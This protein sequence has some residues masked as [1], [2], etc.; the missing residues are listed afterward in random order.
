MIQKENNIRGSDKII[1]SLIHPPLSFLF[2]GIDESNICLQPSLGIAYLSATLRK[3]GHEVVVFDFNTEI[4]SS[5]GTEYKH[6]WN[7]LFVEFW[8][9]EKKFYNTT[10][11]II[12][13]KINNALN[14][15]LYTKPT[16]IGFSLWSTSKLVSCYMAKKIKEK[17]NKSIIIFGGPECT[18]NNA[19]YFIEKVGADAVVIGEGEETL[20]E[21]IRNFKKTGKLNPCKGGFF[22]IE[23]KIIYGGKRELIR[24][25]NTLPFPDFSDFVKNYSA[26]P[27][28]EVILPVSW[29][30]GCVNRC[31]FCYESLF[32]EYPRVRSPEVICEELEY[33][34]KKYNNNIFVKNDSTISI[35]GEHISRVCD[36]LIERQICL[37]WGG[38]ARIENYLTYNLLKK[39]H[40]AGCVYLEYGIESGSQKIVNAMGKNFSLKKAE[41][42]LAATKK[43]GLLCGVHVMYGYPGE[44]LFDFMKTVHFLLKNR[45]SI[46]WV[47]PSRFYLQPSP[48]FINPRKY[49]VSIDENKKWH[50]GKFSNAAPVVLVE[51]Y[52]LLMFNILFYRRIVGQPKHVHKMYKF[53]RAGRKVFKNKK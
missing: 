11:P 33:Q 14:K 4:F 36:I 15:L 1:I 10:L 24:D 53:L 6:L 5:V 39:M 47:I 48:L 27:E 9:D 31:A 46:D 49:E 13:K 7:E 26:S 51:E 41:E 12:N 8:E 23:D 3:E 44:T 22:K 2:G 16:F 20:S 19:K 21:I 42:V 50:T 40:A 43:S 17:N 32:W 34:S 35:S 52:I 45:K 28:E 38:L 18:S 25:I 37:Q 29:M 30:R